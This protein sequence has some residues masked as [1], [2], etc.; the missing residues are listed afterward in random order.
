LTR[1]RDTPYNDANMLQRS[2]TDGSVSPRVDI[3]SQTCGTV[4]LT[5]PVARLFPLW[6][7]GPFLLSGCSLIFTK[8]VPTKYESTP[9]VECS[10]SRVPP[11][12]DT[13][14]GINSLGGAI[15]FA[16]RDGSSNKN[17][18]ASSA[19][20]WAGMWIGSAIYGYR[21]TSAC[22]DVQDDKGDSRTPP[23]PDLK[24]LRPMRAEPDPNLT[25]AN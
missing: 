16:S 4:K 14:L 18:L 6:L 15:Y 1:P 17:L 7:I 23:E 19:A 9:Y 13:I 5:G 11:I 12:L 24:P 10:T 22:E 25:H 3:S 21:A 8:P 2:T 20:V